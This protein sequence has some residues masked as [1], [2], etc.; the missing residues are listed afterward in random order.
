MGRLRLRLRI[1]IKTR[2]YGAFLNLNL[3]R[4]RN[5][6]ILVHGRNEEETRRLDAGAPREVERAKFKWFATIG[7][8]FFILLQICILNT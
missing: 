6:W 5:L 4:N 1:K 2:S 3:A 7:E 8:C